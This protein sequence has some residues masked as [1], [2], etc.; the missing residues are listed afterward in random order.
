MANFA[1]LSSSIIVFLA[2]VHPKNQIKKYDSIH[3]ELDEVPDR[4]DSLPNQN[5]LTAEKVLSPLCVPEECEANLCELTP[6]SND[7]GEVVS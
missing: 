2:D 7:S 1:I 3:A 6:S 4:P 5:S